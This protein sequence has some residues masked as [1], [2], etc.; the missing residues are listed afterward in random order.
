MILP[1]TKS[2]KVYIIILN[3]NQ[4]EDTLICLNS[5]K[6]LK[7]DNYEVIVVDQNSKDGSKEAIKKDYPWVDLIEN[8]DNLGFVEGNNVGIRKVL[9]IEKY[10][11]FFILN[12]DTVVDPDCLDVLVNKAE[13]DKNIGI[14]G[15][16]VFYFDPPNMIFS[17]GAMIDLKH[18]EIHHRHEKEL[19]KEDE[20]APIEVDYISGCSLLI[21]KEVIDKI[22]LMDPRFFIYY[23]ETDWCYRTRR[24]GYKVLYIP[25][26]KIW[27]RVSAAMGKASLSTMYYMTRNQFLFLN[28]N[29]SPA[30]R[31]LPFLLCFIRVVRNILSALKNGRYKEAKVRFVAFNDY[32]FNR[33]GKKQL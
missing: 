28:K 27:H 17:A 4:K 24:A 6:K 30:K 12:N 33:F 25:T 14:A 13:K 3:W 1:K 16:K 2:I 8:D 7:Y 31:L 10:S 32:L 26:C 9:D 18:F 23:E 29:L 22:G 15:P 20:T 19:D 5:V 21:K 11:Y